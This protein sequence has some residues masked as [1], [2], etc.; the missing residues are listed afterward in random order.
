MTE[1]QRIK[2]NSGYGLPFNAGRW[3]WKPS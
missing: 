2:W 3:K 1:A